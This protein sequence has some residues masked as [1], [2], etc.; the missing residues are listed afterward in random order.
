MQHIFSTGIKYIFI[1]T[2]CTEWDETT[3]FEEPK[4]ELLPN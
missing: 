3:S 1:T 2:Y 4:L